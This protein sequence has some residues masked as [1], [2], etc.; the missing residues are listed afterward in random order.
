MPCPMV[1]APR[2][3]TVRI[4]AAA[5]G[6]S[7]IGGTSVCRRGWRWSSGHRRGG[8]PGPRPTS[9]RF[10]HRLGLVALLRAQGGG[11]RCGRGRGRGAVAGRQKRDADA[12][13][14]HEPEDRQPGGG[15]RLVR[16]ERLDG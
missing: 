7:L 8:G 13:E 11:G 9:V 2:T 1:P 3:S 15:A 10:K 12:H 4:F 16:G 5:E 14:E 6:A